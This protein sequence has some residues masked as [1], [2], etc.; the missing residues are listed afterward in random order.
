ML[1]F[2]AMA[3]VYLSATVAWLGSINGDFR[4]S[5]TAL[6][7]RQGRRRLDSSSRL[8]VRVATR[9][10]DSPGMMAAGSGRVDRWWTRI[11]PKNSVRRAPG[12]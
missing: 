11:A 6:V 9:A 8:A 2:A 7:G 1:G 10:I 12:V 4:G 3:A 5:T